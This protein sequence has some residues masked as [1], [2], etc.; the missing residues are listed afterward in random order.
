M[1]VQ[2]R[3]KRER[4]G[5]P[6]GVALLNLVLCFMS[7]LALYPGE[8]LG[9]F[10]WQSVYRCNIIRLCCGCVFWLILSI[11]IRCRYYAGKIADTD[12][13]LMWSTCIFLMFVVLALML[14]QFGAKEYFTA[15]VENMMQPGAFE[16]LHLNPQSR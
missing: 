8:V 4:G 13:R 3:R 7:F 5:K 12:R 15:E 10:G 14:L 16:R 11:S 6:Y 1:D 9:W 2:S